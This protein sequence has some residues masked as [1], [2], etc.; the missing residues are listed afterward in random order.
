MTLIQDGTRKYLE[1]S[2]HCVL[3][4]ISNKS[5]NIDIAHV[6]HRMS[7]FGERAGL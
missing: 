6:E 7:L 1:Y 2:L 4:G 5:P 3:F